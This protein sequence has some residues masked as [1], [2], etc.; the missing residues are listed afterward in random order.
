MILRRCWKQVLEILLLCP[1]MAAGLRA[2]TIVK[3]NIQDLVQEA[4]LIVI[5]TVSSV[6]P[7]WD[8][9]RN[10]PVTIVTATDLEIL[11]G[12]SPGPSLVMEVEGS[13]AGGYLVADMPLPLLGQ[14]NLMFLR[15]PL[16]GKYACPLVGWGQGR[17]ILTTE[18]RTSRQIWIDEQGFPVVGIEN[19]DFVLGT[20]RLEIPG[21]IPESYAMLGRGSSVNSE[22]LLVGSSGG[23]VTAGEPL[24]EASPLDFSAVLQAVREIMAQPDP[25][26]RLFHPVARP[27]GEIPTPTTSGPVAPP[28][29]TPRTPAAPSVA[30]PGHE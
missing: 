7:G 6:E 29:A 8:A 14:R 30:E 21:R 12:A 19:D 23:G 18:P 27:A 26:R 22:P 10:R 24:S 16:R 1:F 20:P 9:V 4:S 13:P 15:Q 25:S 17:L 5:G 3:V 28:S 2:T 11:K